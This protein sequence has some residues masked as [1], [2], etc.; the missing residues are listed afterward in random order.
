MTAG[1]P[2][3]APSATRLYLWIGLTAV[4]CVWQG[5]NW[6]TAIR[7]AP[8]YFFDFSQ[9]WLS[10]RNYFAGQPVYSPQ[11]EAVGWHTEYRPKRA[12]DMLP[13]N[14][15]PPVAIL[16]GLPF[17][18]LPYEQAHL[19]WNIFS[20]IAF[21]LAVILAFRT[22]TTPLDEV[23][24]FQIAALLVVCAPLQVQTFQGQL[25][26]ALVLLVALSWMADRRDWE[27][28]AGALI[29]AAAAIKIV[30]AFLLIAWIARGRWRPVWGAGIAF[31]LLNAVAAILFG[32]S[33]FE[34]Y[35]R[36]I[37]PSVSLYRSSW[38]NISLSG[39]WFKLFDPQEKERVIALWKAPWLAQALAI[40]SQLAVSAI[41][42][43]VC[44]R[45][46]D[47]GQRDHAIAIAI[48]GMLL[49][50]PITWGHYLL[51]LV[52]PLAVESTRPRS[53]PGRTAWGAS[54]IAMWLPIAALA[55]PAMGIKALKQWNVERF[56]LPEATPVQTLAGLEIQLYALLIYFACVYVTF[57]R[58][59]RSAPE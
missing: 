3:S 23:Q 46:H 43:V 21:L 29:G 42:F 18:Q 54:L 33:A 57:P 52:V 28:L 30:P 13:W 11:G 24:F 44:R 27:L 8:G 41:V 48:V 34:T 59:T 26:G 12:D 50:S 25:N 17:C 38:D 2:T 10:G 32:V 19:A 22:R 47:R 7:P 9:E 6:A 45:A 36:T 56:T 15:H 58:A 5:A 1:P 35:I 51:M 40:A 49:V 4:A 20:L 55:A 53:L 37:I 14:A 39:L 16:L 31:I